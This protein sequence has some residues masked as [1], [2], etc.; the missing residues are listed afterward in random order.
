[1]KFQNTS[2]LCARAGATATPS[3][4]PASNIPSILRVNRNLPHAGATGA[5]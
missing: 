1:L 2:P 4:T 3:A 5:S